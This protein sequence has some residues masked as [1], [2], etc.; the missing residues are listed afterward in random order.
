[1]LTIIMLKFCVFIIFFPTFILGLPT[2][3]VKSLGAK[4][5]GKTDATKAFVKAWNEACNSLG[6]LKILVPKGRYLIQSAIKFDGRKCRSTTIDI[7]VKGSIVAPS[8]YQVLKD[9]AIWLSF[10]FVNGVT[11]TGGKFDGKGADLWSCKMSGKGGCPGGATTLAF[12]NSNNIVIRGL[13]SLNSQLFHIAF[14]GCNNVKVQSVKVLAPN[15]SPNTDGIHVQSSNGVTILNSKIS[16]GD[17]CVSVGA[18]TSALWIENVLCGPGHGISIGSLA[19]E[20][21]EAGVQN[22]TVKDVTFV[23]TQNGVRIKSWARPS[24]G[25]VKNV[26]FQ[27]CNMIN[28]QNPILIDQ[29]YCPSKVGCPGKV[30]GVKISDIVYQDIHGSSSTEVAVKFDCSS[31]HPCENIKLDNVKL[32]YKDQPSISSC[33]Y[34]DG[35]TKGMIVPTGCL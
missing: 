12:S 13:T 14:I 6:K 21:N 16:T 17:D 22:V 18:G 23:G 35:S 1:M 33:T 27:Q 7:D 8:D 25:F 24:N 19:K 28:V 2:Y 29:N 3:N 9:S 10:E 15:N 5:D 32:T 34:A 20:L 31:K 11:I 30:S 26:V 4:S